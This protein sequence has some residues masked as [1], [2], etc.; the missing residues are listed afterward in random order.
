MHGFINVKK[1]YFVSDFFMHIMNKTF[2]TIKTLGFDF[3]ID[4]T[5]T[6]IQANVYK[7]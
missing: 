2:K 3:L 1:Q 7:R 6:E 5:N 4:E